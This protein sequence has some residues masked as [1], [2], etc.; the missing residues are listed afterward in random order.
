MTAKK[1]NMPK[2][3]KNKQQKTA[4]VAKSSVEAEKEVL[5]ED[6]SK[7]E[8]VVVDELGTQSD[9]PELSPIDPDEKP[10]FPV[11]VVPPK[12]EELV[13]E[14]GLQKRA[15][16]LN[17][18]QWLS[19]DQYVE[20]MKMSAPNTPQ[21]IAKLQQRFSNALIVLI[22]NEKDDTVAVTNI[23]AILQIIK[24]NSASG[25]AFSPSTYM[26]NIEESRLTKERRTEF[27]VL[28]YT[29]H[30]IATNRK[31]LT[32]DWEMV[33]R[34]LNP[35]HAEEVLSRLFTAANIRVRD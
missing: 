6:G 8:D 12:T 25:E 15:R 3:D 4:Q 16:L 22:A 27:E 20:Q 32:Q 28:Y 35:V 9:V 21:S 1:P 23:K 11:D 14:D 7:Q 10:V 31:E 17:T 33:K 13:F 24:D 2:K 29:L 34:R 30:T 19:I 5:I 18:N 26:R